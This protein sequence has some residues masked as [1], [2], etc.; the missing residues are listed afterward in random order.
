MRA[1]P[2][3]H[4]GL[5]LALV[6]A[7][8]TAGAQTASADAAADG[9]GDGRIALVQTLTAERANDVDHCGASVAT[10]GERLVV[11]APLS[12]AIGSRGAVF[13]YRR[14]LGGPGAW[15]LEATI[16]PP[17]ATVRYFGGAVAV[18]GDVIA[19]SDQS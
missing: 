12:A 1:R 5:A 16:R 14:D 11:G 17:K 4:L 8:R 2:L 15:G 6:A 3:R 19:I 10:D 13:V 18:D 9:G 7:S